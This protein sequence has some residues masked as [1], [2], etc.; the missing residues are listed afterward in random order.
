MLPA[1]PWYVA[2]ITA[3]PLASGVTS[4]AAE[5]LAT[6]ESEERHPACDVTSCVLPS[7]KPATAESWYCVPVAA[8]VTVSERGTGLGLAGSLQA[9]TRAATTS[10][11]YRLRSMS[12]WRTRTAG[13]A[14]P[15]PI[16]A[17][18][19]DGGRAHQ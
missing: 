13:A 10:R 1:T 12:G 16:R 15:V 6:V 4:P 3:D 19:E 9:A 14:K 17:R 18:R 2:E 8:A 5:T 7:E 11:T